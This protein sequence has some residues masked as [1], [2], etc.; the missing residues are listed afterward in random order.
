MSVLLLHKGRLPGDSGSGVIIDAILIADRPITGRDRRRQPPHGRWRP[1]TAAPR[2]GDC[3]PACLAIGDAHGG[4]G[5]ACLQLIAGQHCAGPNAK[6]PRLRA[7]RRAPRQSE[8]SRAARPAPAGTWAPNA[9]HGSA[10]GGPLRVSG[11][12][13]GLAGIRCA[14]SSSNWSGRSP[15]HVKPLPINVDG[16]IAAV[17]YDLGFPAALAKLFFII[18]RVAD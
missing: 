1:A 9:Q 14:R 8:G 11:T 16:A 13:A 3:A 17:L 18:G 4:A 2:G 15:R 6:A 12:V 7:T 10:H 5:L